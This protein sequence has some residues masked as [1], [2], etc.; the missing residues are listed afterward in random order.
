MTLVDSHCHLDYEDFAADL[1]GVLER[2][3][4]AGVGTMLTI[5][6]RLSSFDKVLAVA[7]RYDNVYCTVGIHPHEA[8]REPEIDALRLIDMARHPK[9]V[10]F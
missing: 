7:E 4:A 10:G 6:T 5:G 1:D 8:D 9:V 3:A 2:A